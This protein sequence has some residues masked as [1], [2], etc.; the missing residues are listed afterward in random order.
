MSMLCRLL[1][2][3]ENHIKVPSGQY[4]AKQ[5]HVRQVHDMTDEMA[6]ELA[7]LS[8]FTAYAKIIQENEG[9]T[10]C[11]EWLDMHKKP[12]TTGDDCR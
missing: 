8:R 3:P 7:N 1:S 9:D 12:A 2:R 4:I 6:Q 10:V 5:V 11:M